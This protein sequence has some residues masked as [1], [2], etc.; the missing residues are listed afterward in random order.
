MKLH[1]ELQGRLS[2]LTSERDQLLRDKTELEQKINDEGLSVSELQQKLATTVAELTTSVRT[3]QQTQA[4][5]RN[6]NRRAD[7]AEKI[8]KD[9]QAEGIGLMR[10]LEEMRPKIVEL[11][12]AKLD[13][14]EKRS[15]VMATST[16]KKKKLRFKLR[17]LDRYEYGTSMEYSR[18]YSHTGRMSLK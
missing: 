13:L 7:E 8:Q 18:M 10:S 9:L 16:S 5:L 11:T 14:G 3:L 12:D 2:S 15:V 6:A 1:E 17:R 4:E